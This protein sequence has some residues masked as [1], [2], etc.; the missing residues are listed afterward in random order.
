MKK[1][2]MILQPNQF[3]SFTSYYLEEYWKQWFDIMGDLKLGDYD[4]E[5]QRILEHNHA[6]FF[7]ETLVKSVIHREIVEPLLEYAET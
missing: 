3:T 5:T 6:H 1:I 2:D 4:R 7:D